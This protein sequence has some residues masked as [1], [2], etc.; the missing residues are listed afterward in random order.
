M[1]GKKEK[2]F[3]QGIGVGVLI[4]FGSILAGAALAFII[5]NRF[6]PQLTLYQNTKPAASEVADNSD[7][8]N[9]ERV[10]KKLK[11]LEELVDKQY[12]F[13]A[14][15]QAAE[16][17]IYRGYMEGLGDKYTTYFTAEEYKKLTDSMNGVFYG[18]GAVVQQDPD[19][20]VVTVVSLIDG[21][22]AQKAGV[23]Q[24]DI[25]YAVGD[26]EVSGMTLDELVYE[27]IH[28]EKDTEV[29]ITF[30]SD[31][32]K[33][34]I[35]MK[36][37]EVPQTTVYSELLRDHI[38][39]IE[40]VQFTEETVP[41]FV[42]AVEDM[43]KAGADGLVIDL[44]NNTGGVLKACVEMLDYLLP[45]AVK[46]HDGL[47]TYTADKNGVGERYYAKD[48]HKTDLPIVILV[49]GYSASASE[50]FT[51][52]MMDYGAATVVGTQTFGKGIVQN[53]LPLGDGSAVKIT[54]EHYYTPDGTDLHGE[55][56][57]PD[58]VVELD[59]A[60]KKYTDEKDTQFAAAVKL[61]E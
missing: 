10:E 50:V 36:R 31:G 30:I 8:L 41:Q 58:V 14:D 43:E 9:M 20:K 21:A 6:F 27:Y 45:D 55:G 49:N 3:K 1:N 40:I 53:V 11:A 16:D 51:G 44:R 42:N 61:L 57:T 38:G 60:C 52:A 59:E 29:T 7:N 34:D 4:A 19:T 35:T 18:I 22:P 33:K 47:I 5:L 23:K 17:G 24:G 26:A 56:L 37:G 46:E 39:Y 12:L 32:V 15:A 25:I 54:T 2:T 13:E 28:G 48:G